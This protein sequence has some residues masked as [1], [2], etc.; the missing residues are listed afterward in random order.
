MPEAFLGLFPGQVLP[1]VPQLEP[2]AAT[3]GG[4]RTRARNQ[5]GEFKADDPATPEVNEAYAE[6]ED[7]EP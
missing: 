5:Q 3:G 6:L 4:K 2:P 1:L 7:G